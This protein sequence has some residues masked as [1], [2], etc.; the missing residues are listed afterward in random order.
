[1]ATLAPPNLFKLYALLRPYLSSLRIGGIVGDLSHVAGG[2]YHISREDLKA[3]G[4]TSDYSIQAPAD[5]RGQPDYAGGIDISL[6][7]REMALVSTR[8]RAAMTGPDYDPRIEPLR[9]FIGTVDGKNV[10]GYNRYQTVYPNGNRGRRAGWYASGYSES[11][12]LWHVHVSFFRAYDQSWNEILGVAEVICG[13]APGKLGWQGKTVA[14]TVKPKPVQTGPH[15]EHLYTMW[16]THDGTKG[17]KLPPAVGVVKH[18]RKKGFRVVGYPV[19]RGD[20][21]YLRTLYGTDYPLDSL[22]HNKPAK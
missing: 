2:G 21:K 10:C 19:R 16:T 15:G 13:L 1:L 12:H 7:P 3:H 11:S 20:G 5:H 4:Q 6:D 17:Y 9:E 18:T 14:P 22:T 8:L